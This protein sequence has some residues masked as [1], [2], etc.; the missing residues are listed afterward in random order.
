MLEDLFS[1]PSKKETIRYIH[2]CF[3][4]PNQNVTNEDLYI[5]IYIYVGFELNH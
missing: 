3:K 2:R 1:K 4:I 5:Y